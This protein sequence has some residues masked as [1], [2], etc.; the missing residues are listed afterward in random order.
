[1]V[2][3]M[4]TA[5]NIINEWIK[6][7]DNKAILC[8][9]YL[10]LEKLPRL[11]QSLQRLWCYN[12]QIKELPQL[13]QSLQILW[14]SNNQIKELPQLPQS[15][16]ELNCYNNQIKELPQLPQSLQELYCDNNQIK[17]PKPDTRSVSRAFSFCDKNCRK[18]QRGA[19]VYACRAG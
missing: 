18:L 17:E 13:P 4:E 16:R 2:Q 10:G 7:G 15:L 11:P 12:N 14:C 3:S 1:M 8:L 9:S 6:K 19:G 5:I